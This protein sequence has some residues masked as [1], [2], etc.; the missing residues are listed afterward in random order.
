M[1]FNARKGKKEQ[2]ASGKHFRG[3]RK[4]D[5]KGKRKKTVVKGSYLRAKSHYEFE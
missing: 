4:K 3:R 2:L 5:M 1:L